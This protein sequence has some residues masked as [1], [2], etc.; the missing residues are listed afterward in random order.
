MQLQNDRMS[1]EEL[2]DLLKE[3]NQTLKY[4]KEAGERFSKEANITLAKALDAYIHWEQRIK[5]TTQVGE[6]R[7]KMKTQV[8]EK[9]LK[10]QAHDAEQCIERKIED[11]IVRIKQAANETAQVDYERDLEGSL[12][13]FVCAHKC[14]SI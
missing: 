12:T 14:D 11:G 1:M 6:K 4:A 7:L 3:A 10:C 8:G 5:K 2:G 9:R 13:V